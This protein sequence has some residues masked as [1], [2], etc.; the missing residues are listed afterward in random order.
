[1]TNRI[2]ILGCNGF[3]G[4]ALWEKLS[5]DPRRE[6]SGFSSADCDLLSIESARRALADRR[7][8]DTIVMTSAI[9][10]IKENTFEAMV[11]NMRMAENITQILSVTPVGQFIFL[12]SI[13]IYGSLEKNSDGNSAKINEDSELRPDEY[14]GI[15][16]SGCEFLL[17]EKL[18]SLGTAL[19]VLRFPGVYGAG[20]ESKS[21]IGRF[22][23]GA[24]SE[25][26]ILIDGD[27][28]DLRDYIYIDDVCR[29]VEQAIA[30]RLN[31]AVNVVS[32]KSYSIRRIAEMIKTILV[33]DCAI[34]FQERQGPENTRKRFMQFDNA[35]LLKVLPDLNL[36]DLSEGISRFIKESEKQPAA[37]AG[38]CDRGPQR[39]DNCELRRKI[40]DIVYQA[41]GGHIPSAFSIIDILAYLYG[42]VLKFDPANPQSPQRDY[43]ILSKGHGCAALYVL[44]EKY[45]FITQKDLDRLAKFD[46]ILGGHPD[47]TKVPGAE[48]STGSL[49]HGIGTALGAALGLRIKKMNNRVFVLIGDGESNEGTV[50][51]NALVAAN[52]KLGNFCCI[53]D[54]NGSAAQI[55]PISPLREK[56]ESFGWE[57][58]VV[59]GHRTGDLAQVFGRLQFSPEGRPKI[60]IAQ[61]VKGKGVSFMETH[62]P[63]HYR[64]PSAVELE[65]IYRELDP[66]LR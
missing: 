66:C 24:R 17:K 25:G 59:D 54:Y 15:G 42:N 2:I 27:G 29:A 38:G 10:R 28:S 62:G 56:W 51:E 1:M 64:V 16:K 33:S 22:I 60:V 14:Y 26:K 40:V 5:G 9:T 53:L 21:L 8:D 3:I 19:A 4:R 49:G 45:G 43:F 23:Q 61:T 11:K 18:S 36:C 44:L 47:S 30:V 34:E 12:S 7:P 57:T 48:G 13:D 50:W 63:W 39:L 6:I 37:A 32:R 46:G 31:Q 41:G 35:R 20:D 52:L 58:L 55:L 65:K